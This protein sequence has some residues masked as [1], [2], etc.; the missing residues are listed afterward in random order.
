[1]ITNF[2]NLEKYD[3]SKSKCI[4][5]IIKK[6]NLLLLLYNKIIN[7]FKN[8]RYCYCYNNELD[9]HKNSYL[10]ENIKKG[11]ARFDKLLTLEGDFSDIINIIRI[12]NTYFLNELNIFFVKDNYPDIF[13]KMEE[14]H[15]SIKNY[16]EEHIFSKLLSLE[17]NQKLLIDNQKIIIESLNQINGNNYTIQVNK[18]LQKNSKNIQQY[19][20]LLKF[21][22]DIS[23][24]LT[25]Y[26]M[27]STVLSSGEINVNQ[28]MIHTTTS[29][30]LGIVNVSD[31][32]GQSLPLGSVVTNIMNAAGLYYINNKQL[33]DNL[34]YYGMIDSVIHTEGMSKL[35]SLKIIKQ[36]NIDK[37]NDDQINDKY[38]DYLTNIWRE[39]QLNLIKEQ[40]FP[41]FNNNTD[42]IE[43]L[44]INITH[45]HFNI[46]EI[47]LQEFI[48][49]INQD[50]YTS[51]CCNMMKCIK[52]K[53]LI[54]NNIVY[55]DNLNNFIYLYEIK[56]YF[57]YWKNVYMCSIY[58]Q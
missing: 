32:V 29:V 18:Y 23:K 45:Y 55:D 9:T 19:N 15:I 3:I 7:E 2:K 6:K 52:K 27:S 37:I 28:S 58:K 42:I 44:V 10:L 43:K 11:I 30:A 50:T 53:N 56:R 48:T 1:M 17:K 16:I 57:T 54:K 22:N 20:L 38:V 14:T 25:S 26:N 4:T 39:A 31:A 41:L 24:K 36:L 49:I 8:T 34:N 12:S 47:T 40:K 5:F 21:Y 46:C 33:N 13:L 51:Q 35:N